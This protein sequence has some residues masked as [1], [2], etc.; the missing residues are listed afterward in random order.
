MRVSS[1]SCCCKT[2]QLNKW[3]LNTGGLDQ[4]IGNTE[5]YNAGQIFTSAQNYCSRD[6]KHVLLPSTCC[7]TNTTKCALI[8]KQ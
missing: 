4:E 2:K 3:M 6:S 8:C 5:Q 1:C 7:T